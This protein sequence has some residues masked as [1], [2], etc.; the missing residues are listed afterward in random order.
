[1]TTMIVK[2]KNGYRGIA[3]IVPVPALSTGTGMMTVRIPHLG[4]EC[5]FPPAYQ[6]EESSWLINNLIVKQ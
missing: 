1:M 3:L 4:N 5:S 6:W 2:N